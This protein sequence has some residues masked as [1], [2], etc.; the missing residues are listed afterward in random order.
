MVQHI[1]DSFIKNT[2]VSSIF[3][4]IY[5]STL[6]QSPPLMSSFM[7]TDLDNQKRPHRSWHELVVRRRSYLINSFECEGC[8][9]R[10]VNVQHLFWSKYRSVSDVIIMIRFVSVL[11]RWGSGIHLYTQSFNTWELLGSLR[12]WIRCLVCIR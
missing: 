4:N 3:T 5:Q 2:T 7:V 9:L 10:F 8:Q 12:W 11:S 6:S 1:P